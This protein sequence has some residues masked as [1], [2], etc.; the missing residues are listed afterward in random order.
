MWIPDGMIA[1][2]M[3]SLIDGAIQNATSKHVLKQLLQKGPSFI[4]G[5]PRRASIS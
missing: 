1:S 5:I 4:S 3:D 2:S